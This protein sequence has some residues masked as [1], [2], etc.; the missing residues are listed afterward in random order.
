M[1]KPVKI[2]R[3]ETMLFPDHGL[4]RSGFTEADIKTADAKK[5]AQEIIEAWAHYGPYPLRPLLKRA[6]YVP[7]GNGSI[8][9]PAEPL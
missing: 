8:A 7:K 6:G 1:K 3:D 4:Y 5:V 9:V 2:F